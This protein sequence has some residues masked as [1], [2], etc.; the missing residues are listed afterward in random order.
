MNTKIILSAII[1]MSVVLVTG[2][3]FAYD[4]WPAEISPLA[5]KYAGRDVNSI[6]W[7]EKNLHTANELKSEVI[8]VYI[9]ESLKLEYL[10]NLNKEKYQQVLGLLDVS[11]KQAQSD[12]QSMIGT[13]QQPGWLL[14]GLLTLLP[15]GSYIAGWR[16]LWP[17]HYTE[18]EVQAEIAKAKTPRPTIA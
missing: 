10:A 4:F 13:I 1:V 14:A 16:T 7:Y 6:C 8:D 5:L 11:I 3:Q 2:C 18:Q 9:G 15:V 12:R 17:N